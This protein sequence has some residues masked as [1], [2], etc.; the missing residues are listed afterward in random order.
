MFDFKCFTFFQ[1]NHY[2]KLNVR[3]GRDKNKVHGYGLAFSTA[4]VLITA[5]DRMSGFV[6]ITNLPTSKA[7]GTNNS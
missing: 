1:I 2:F 4:I 6:L 3:A 7:S 5:T